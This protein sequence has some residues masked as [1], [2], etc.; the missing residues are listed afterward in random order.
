MDLNYVDES[1]INV[2]KVAYIQK[3]TPLNFLQKTIIGWTRTENNIWILYLQSEEEINIYLQII[4][5][6]NGTPGSKFT[7]VITLSN[8]E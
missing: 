6:E 8:E 2:N 7:F 1:V 5:K 3:N 4:I